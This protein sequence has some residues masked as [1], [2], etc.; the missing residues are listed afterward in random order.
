MQVH[1][2]FGE[3]VRNCIGWGFF[4]RDF[5]RFPKK[6]SK[7]ECT[8]RSLCLNYRI[9]TEQKYKGV[10]DYCGGEGKVEQTKNNNNNKRMGIGRVRFQTGNWE[11]GLFKIIV[12]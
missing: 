7:V 4:R 8:A 9:K 10:C 6:I 2:N 11:L 3:T 5:Q 12:I 1:G